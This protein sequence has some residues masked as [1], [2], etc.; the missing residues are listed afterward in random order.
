M[1]RLENIINRDRISHVTG[2][3]RTDRIMVLKKIYDNLYLQG[4]ISYLL[5]PHMIHLPPFPGYCRAGTPHL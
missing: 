4:G 5:H 2:G 3:A 1:N